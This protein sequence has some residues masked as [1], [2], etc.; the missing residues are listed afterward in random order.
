MESA[1]HGT[2]RA[3]AA[4]QLSPRQ[5]S[6]Q[7]GG[8]GGEAADDELVQMLHA[9]ARHHEALRR[10]FLL[11]AMPGLLQA[12]KAGDAA[13]AVRLL[14]SGAN[15]DQPE[16][17]PSMQGGGS[18]ASGGALVVVPG[19]RWAPLHYA[20][21]HG[22]AAVVAALLAGGATAAVAAPPDS[23]SS[24]PMDLAEGHGHLRCALLI[25]L[26]T[27]SSGGGLPRL[28]SWSGGRGGD[29]GGAAGGTAGAIQAMEARWRDKLVAAEAERAKLVRQLQHAESR[30]RAAARR[31]SSSGGGLLGAVPPCPVCMDRGRDTALVPCGH[32]ACNQCALALRRQRGTCAE[33]NATIHGL[34]LLYGLGLG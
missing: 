18:R 4:A 24:S 2:P 1:A 8:G 3:A 5:C 9:A 25:K 7:G 22:H 12:A 26:H 21:A 27:Q 28:P 19:Q 31:G 10:R 11:T 14:A 17:V 30:L 34:L 16:E 32:T 29:G 33:C 15:P 23:K 13:Q 6:Q 20:C